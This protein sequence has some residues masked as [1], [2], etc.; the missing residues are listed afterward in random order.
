[1]ERRQA[2]RL[3]RRALGAALALLAASL[4]AAPSAHAY[5]FDEHEAIGYETY[6]EACARL[7]WTAGALDTFARRVRFRA[8]CGRPEEVEASARLVRT[9]RLRTDVRYRAAVRV[10]DAQ[11]RLGGTDAA[12][13]SAAAR[14][15]VEAERTGRSA[16]TWLAARGLAPD[17]AWPLQDALDALDAL[18]LLGERADAITGEVR[19]LHALERTAHWAERAH[20][21]AQAAALA[22]DHVA[23]PDELMGPAGE[24]SAASLSEYSLLARVNYEH[25]HPYV[26]RG[27]R[28]YHADALAIAL[29]AARASEP[30]S[31]T[32]IRRA[33]LVNAFA[34]HYLHDAFASGHMAFNRVASSVTASAAFHDVWN[35]R[36]RWVVNRRGDTWRAVGDGLL[37]T[38]E[39]Q[40]HRAHLLDAA[41]SSVLDVLHAYVMGE[42]RVCSPSAEDELPTAVWVRREGHLVAPVALGVEPRW[43]LSSLEAVFLRAHTALQLG[44]YYGA[45]VH[46]GPDCVAH[47]GGAILDTDYFGLQT[48]RSDALAR[49][50][51]HLLVGG[52]SRCG[53]SSLEVGV[54]GSLQLGYTS[55]GLLDHRLTA[56][57][58]L[59]HVGGAFGYK[60]SLN[61]ERAVISIWPQYV[62]GSGL[63]KDGH[64]IATLVSL[65]YA[66]GSKGG[67]IMGGVAPAE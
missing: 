46:L 8:V 4:G 63:G 49:L 2:Q 16:Q 37:R 28:R 10:I 23:S 32:A 62:A 42:L 48:L 13:L 21:Y 19:R 57:L 66:I 12:T 54:G 56:T 26:L 41:T 40:E 22:G 24:A 1:M 67:G 61:L 25:F 35:A 30:A 3:T 36:G 55:A 64:E 34:D 27:F 53:R 17:G 47:G 52:T 51:A 11:Q 6:R 38:P 60:L 59:P 39:A 50:R 20:F 9:R 44:A 45:E 7:S 65:E 18:A 58:L 14:A 5:D 29:A 33:L 31:E 15:I 43:T